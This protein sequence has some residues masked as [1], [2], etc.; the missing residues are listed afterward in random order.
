MCGWIEWNESRRRFDPFDPR[1]KAKSAK[2]TVWMDRMDRITGIR[3][4]QATGKQ[5]KEPCGRTASL[6]EKAAGSAATYPAP[7]RS[8]GMGG[9]QS[10]KAVFSNALRLKNTPPL[11][12]FVAGTLAGRVRTRR[13][14]PYPSSGDLCTASP[15]KVPLGEAARP[16]TKS[17]PPP[18][19]GVRGQGL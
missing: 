19:A 12:F 10:C 13:S 14:L 11:G 15:L 3:S 9:V 5:S 4:T 1:E 18:F 7:P 8:G 17:G 2:L 6:Y 16:L